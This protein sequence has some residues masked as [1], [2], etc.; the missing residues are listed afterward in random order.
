MDP[1]L[2]RFLSGVAIVSLIFLALEYHSRAALGDRGEN[3]GI[4]IQGLVRVLHFEI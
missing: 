4:N 2:R 1:S 3:R